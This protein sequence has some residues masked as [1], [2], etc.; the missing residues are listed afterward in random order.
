MAV[1]ADDERA[2]LDFAVSPPYHRVMDI[3]ILDAKISGNHIKAKLD[4]LKMAQEEAARR[5]GS[6]YRHFNRIVLG[7]ADPT[8][9][10]AYKI[11][12]V[13]GSTVAELF[14]VKLK[15]RK[16]RKSQ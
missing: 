12:E 11:A 8:L 7:Q 2:G 9:L 13:T 3:E 16:T 15:S 1:F 10:T 14:D 4:S 5:V 6:S